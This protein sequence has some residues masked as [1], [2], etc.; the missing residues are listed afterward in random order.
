LGDNSADTKSK[1]KRQAR[2][3][4]HLG[5]GGGGGGKIGKRE[6]IE[7]EMLQQRRLGGG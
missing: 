5:I 6:I 3:Q 4:G 2:K 1:T 7:R